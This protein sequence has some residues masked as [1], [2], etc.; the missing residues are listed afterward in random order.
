[1]EFNVSE[2]AAYAVLYGI[3]FLFALLA[4]G[5]AGW[6]HEYVPT[7]LANVC[8]LQRQQRELLHQKQNENDGAP[9]RTLLSSSDYF[10]AARNSAGPWTLGL[11]YFA[12]GVRI[13]VYTQAT[14]HTS[15]TIS[16]V[17]DGR[18]GSVRYH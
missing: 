14:M 12:S 15:L 17:Q 11:S 10:L 4:L 3:L 9:M 1:M 18:L 7:W 2:G 6:F 16:V 13:P 8:L 5:S